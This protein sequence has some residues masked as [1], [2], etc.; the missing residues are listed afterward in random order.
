MLINQHITKARAAARMRGITMI[1]LM[2]V[3]VVLSILAAIAYPSYQNQVTK[4]R[5]ADGMG[6]AA[7]DG[8]GSR[9][10]PYTF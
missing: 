6:N 3:I 4:A 8:A 10:L 9:A 7:T 1:E 5:R 2:I